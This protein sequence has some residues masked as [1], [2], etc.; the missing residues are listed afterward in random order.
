MKTTYRSIDP[1]TG[2]LVTER[3][4]ASS[5]EVEAALTSVARAYR[6]WSAEPLAHRADA[7]R[8]IASRLRA[9]ASSDAQ[10]MVE[11]MGKPLTQALAEIEKCAWSCA[12]AADQAEA[13]LAPEIVPT[14]AR[15]S[16][17]RH[18]PLGPILAI[19]PWNF[20]FWQVFRVGASALVAGDTI[21][22]KHA[23]NVPR[24]AEAIV[25]IC[26]EAGLPDGVVTNMFARVDQVEGI[27]A[28]RRIAAV[29]LTG[30][31]R[32][33][34][35]VA[36]LA[37]KHLKPSVL[38]LGGSDPFLV[39]EDADLDLAAEV[40]A[41]ARLQNNGQSCIAAKRFIVVEAVARAFEARLRA[42]LERV[43]LGDPR[44]PATELGPMARADLRDELADQVARSVAKG[45]RLVL[46]GQVPRRDGWWYPATL[47]V[48]A[49]P[50]MPAWDDETFGPAAAM[51]VVRNDDEAVA[52]ANANP[53]GLGAAV[54]T[55]DVDRGERLAARLEAGSVFVNDLVRSDARLPVGG[56]KDSGWGRE[57]GREGMRQL[58]N[59]KT[60][61]VA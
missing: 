13:W 52:V 44:D 53:Y 38:E 49:G 12:Y 43:A 30:S 24:C 55:E 48:E 36:S 35:A 25:A 46:G 56:V 21:L 32:A 20:P 1:T 4:E 58:T 2:H 31:A 9:R 41:K 42:R 45:G 23:P 34:R 54:W 61:W 15:R 5:A 29:T 18:D 8:R 47:V 26:R 60:V 16:V 10:T 28:D 27:L 3:P 50:G 33:G 14:E 51:T 59:T 17:V 40:G 19:M 39:L 7:L 11:E 22:L 6:G 37:G 57:L